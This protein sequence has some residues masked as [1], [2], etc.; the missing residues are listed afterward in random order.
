[1]K[2]YE[3]EDEFYIHAVTGLKNVYQ[4]QNESS[5][6]LFVINTL[7]LSISKIFQQNPR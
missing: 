2:D 4:L 5:K 6:D 3:V 7:Q 1:M